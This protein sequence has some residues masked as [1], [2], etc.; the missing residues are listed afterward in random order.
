MTDLIR[1]NGKPQPVSAGATL[2]DVIA[3]LGLAAAGRGVAA[4]LNEAV[5]PARRWDS[6]PVAPGD[7]IEVI[8]ALQGG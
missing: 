5:V 6:T 8:R 7:R 1:V 2:A 3:G 4:A